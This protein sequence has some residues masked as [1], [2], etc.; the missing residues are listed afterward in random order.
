[1]PVLDLN[2][3]LINFVANLSLAGLEQSVAII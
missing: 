1:M 3:L 2:K